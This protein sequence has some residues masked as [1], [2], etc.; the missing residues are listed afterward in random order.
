[1][2]FLK[3]YKNIFLFVFELP[4]SVVSNSMLKTNFKLHF[5]LLCF[6]LI[7]VF[8]L[9]ATN[10]TWTTDGSG[11]WNTVGNWNVGAGFPNSAS[12]NAS[13][14]ILGMTGINT[15][16]LTSD[17]TIGNIDSR[18]GVGP[19]R[20]YIISG[21]PNILT[22]NG[23]VGS[24]SGSGDLTIQCPMQ[25]AS[26][27]TFSSTGILTNISIDFANNGSI[28]GSNGLTIGANTNLL[29]SSSDGFNVSGGISIA[30]GSSLS[31]TVPENKTLSNSF[32]GSGTITKLGEGDLILG[33]DS[34]DFT[35]A[36]TISAG[37][38]TTSA[39]T[40]LPV[41][42]A[43][44]VSGSATLQINNSNTIGSLTGTGSLRIGTGATLTVGNANSQQF[45][46]PIFGVGTAG[47]TKAG[48]GTWTLSAPLS[49]TGAVSS[50]GGGALAF[51]QSS[52]CGSIAGTSTISI[53]ADKVLTAGS[54]N[55]STTFSGV[56]AGAG[57]FTKVGTGNLI[58]SG[59]NTLSGSINA[60][61][62]TLTVNGSFPGGTTI[63][64]GS[65]ATFKG[66]GSIGSLSVSGIFAPG[67]S[68]GTTTVLGDYTQNT[69][70]TLEIEFN[71][72]GQ[73]DLIDVTGNATIQN[74]ATLTLLPQPGIY[75]DGTQYT[76]LTANALSGVFDTV[77][78][79]NSNLGPVTTSLTY[80]AN[81]ILLTLS[82]T[83]APTSLNSY[84]LALNNDLNQL[85]SQTQKSSLNQR[86]NQFLLKAKPCRNS[87]LCTKNGKSKSHLKRS[88]D[89]FSQQC[90]SDKRM[91]TP[92][93]QFG[94]ATGE[95]KPTDNN[96]ANKY[97]VYAPFVGLEL[98]PLKNL[99]LGLGFNYDNANTQDLLKRG[100]INSNTYGFSFYSE[101]LARSFLGVGLNTTTGWT[102][103]SISH[104]ASVETA[105]ANPKGWF[106]Q[107]EFGLN[108]ML[109]FNH[110]L[111][112]PIAKVAY[113]HM[114]ISS[115]TE[116]GATN[117]LK[118]N[119]DKV[120][121]FSGE[122]GV[123][124]APEIFLDCSVIIPQIAITQ[125][126]PFNQVRRSVYVQN[127]LETASKY[128]FI[129]NSNLYITKCSLTL[130][131][132]S[133]EKFNCYSSAAYLINSGLKNA[134][135]I[136]AGVGVFF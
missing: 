121:S 62:G 110:F 88:N 59:A 102:E 82:G 16:T 106:I 21:T 51:E 15:L 83:N 84:M 52:S 86:I 58:L 69:G 65:S 129:D 60:N 30:S 20:N 40:V 41:A 19:I 22:V 44:T 64:V 104:K 99:L 124:F 56:L 42:S 3:I 39:Q 66:T 98:T 8:Q 37:S 96:A 27:A 13:L 81:S 31:L 79:G 93:I 2:F 115:Y 105:R 75:T 35:G 120:N 33:G 90:D 92:F 38:I 80:G 135:E 18:S 5:F 4:I 134:F 126:I 48:S 23:K 133:K 112:M 57:G 111:F 107:T 67:A 12:D 9:S 73:K 123:S 72:A 89:K 61:A 29:V 55:T 32:T 97:K 116:K 47:L 45:D 14:P 118:V 71:G 6:T 50:N 11:D 132:I 91:L 17:I 46:G 95:F 109:C 25:V 68:I 87:N 117:K 54:A 130:S 100:S 77:E 128:A 43:F 101:Y 94:Y 136:F 78:L 119:S 28:I 10:F 1:M 131:Y 122:F 70:S 127:T 113:N 36:V 114:Q 53:A 85:L 103:Y 76:F 34:R 108:P 125:N 74:G 7:T 26:G 24:N 63:T 49:L